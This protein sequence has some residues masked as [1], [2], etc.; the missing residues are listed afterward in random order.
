MITEVRID[1]ER[2]NRLPV[3]ATPTYVINGVVIKGSLA[4][5]Y[6][7]AAILYELKQGEVDTVN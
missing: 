4:P 7:D 2:G 6:F 1:I 5:Q 3:E